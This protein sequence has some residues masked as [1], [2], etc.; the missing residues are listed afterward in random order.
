V[1]PILEARA[2]GQ[3]GAFTY[4]QARAAGYTEAEVR[5]R[6]ASGRW[7]R[8]R[9]GAYASAATW[10]AADERARHGILAVSA[11]LT[12]GADTAVSHTSAAVLLGAP[13][14]GW[15]DQVHVT[16][17]SGGHQ[18]SGTRVHRA[19][20]PAED[21]LARAG[22]RVTTPAR[23]LI[24]VA[25]TEPFRAAVVIAD[26]LLRAGLLDAAHL[27]AMRGTPLTGRGAG[28]ARRV[29]AFATGLSDN[30]G[31]S[32]SRVAIHTAG[33]PPPELQ[34]EI[35]PRGPDGPGI[36]VDF[37]WRRQRLVGEF[38]GR[39]KYQAPAD[40]YAEKRREDRIRA[41]GYGVVRWG[42]AEAYGDF[43]PTAA[44][45]RAQLASGA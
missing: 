28:A 38:D 34:V 36:R 35:S 3:L 18:L 20:L 26:G 15:P 10:D 2:A 14:L 11:A 22:I 23:T 45:I 1:L 5:A 32:L 9:R 30:P 12:V 4:A 21:V 43:G 13:T 44:R 42:W 25:R 8:L 27:D 40:L 17:G 19:P 6:V 39:L 31:E 37:L 7:L 33:L 24:D 29:V 41:M 16:R